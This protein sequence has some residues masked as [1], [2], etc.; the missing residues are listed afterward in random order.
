MNEAV[1]NDSDEVQFIGADTS[2][3]RTYI[4]GAYVDAWRKCAPLV[5]RSWLVNK[6]IP[7]EDMFYERSSGTG[8]IPLPDDYFMLTSFKLKRWRKTVQQAV[9]EGSAIA[10][11]QQNKYT[12]GSYIRPVCVI[13]TKQIDDKISQVLSFYSLP[14]GSKSAEIEEAIYIPLVKQIINDDCN[15]TDDY[16]NLKID[17]RLLEPLSYMNAS[18]VYE[19]FEKNEISKLLEQKSIEMINQNI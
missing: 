6:L 14:A 8:Y 17:R 16:Q 10:K 11:L 12:M 2:T 9:N 15:Y 1:R 3:V 19:L 13:R 7:T 5:P 18:I 4:E